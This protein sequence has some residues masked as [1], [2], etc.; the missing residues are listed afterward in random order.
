M[1]YEKLVSSFWVL[2]VYKLDRAVAMGNWTGGKRGVVKEQ[3]V[4]DFWCFLSCLF[5]HPVT[6][7]I[8]ARGKV[9]Q[10]NRPTS[11]GGLT[12]FELIGSGDYISSTSSRTTSRFIGVFIGLFW[13]TPL[14]ESKN[15]VSIKLIG[16]AIASEGNRTSASTVLSKHLQDITPFRFP[17]IDQSTLHDWSERTVTDG[18]YST[19]RGISIHDGLSEPQLPSLRHGSQ[20]G[21]I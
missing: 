11:I 19:R 10:V 6:H 8:I 2:W 16:S 13:H 12:K 21:S 20:G 7:K 17:E 15:K 3:E 9:L 1:F 4:K 5:L 14:E 18:R